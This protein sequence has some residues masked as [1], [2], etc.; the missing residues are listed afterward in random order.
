MLHDLDKTLEK[1]IMKEGNIPSGEID[2][3]FDQPTGEWSSRLSR[4]TLNC[5]CFDLRENLKLR[6]I[7]RNVERMPNGNTSVSTFAPRR[8]DAMYLITAWARKAEDE[9]Q[10]LWRALATLKRFTTLDPKRCEGD[11]RYQTLPIPLLVA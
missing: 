1:L 9:H 8:I 11:L 3:G 5:W 7:D 2:I 10:L 4:P 6:S